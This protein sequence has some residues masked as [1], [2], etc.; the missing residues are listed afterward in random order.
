MIKS[1]NVSVIS[2]AWYAGI[3]WVVCRSKEDL[4]DGL[5]FHKTALVTISLLLVIT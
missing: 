1:I 5:V 4:P 2:T 3:R